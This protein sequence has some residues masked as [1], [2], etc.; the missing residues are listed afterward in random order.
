MQSGR[1]TF[2]DMA[3]DEYDAL[4]DTPTELSLPRETV[5]ALVRAGRGVVV[6]N[7]AVAEFRE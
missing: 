5:D 4:Y 3:A 7:G 6:R 1:S 2:R